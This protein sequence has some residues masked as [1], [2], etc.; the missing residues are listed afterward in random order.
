MVESTI[1][2]ETTTASFKGKKAQIEAFTEEE[3]EDGLIIA[4]GYTVNSLGRGNFTVDTVGGEDAIDHF[5]LNLD[6][7]NDGEVQSLRS[8]RDALNNSEVEEVAEEVE[9]AEETEPYT[10]PVDGLDEDTSPQQSKPKG[11]PKKSKEI[12]SEEYHE[13]EDYRGNTEALPAD[14]YTHRLECECGNI[15]W[16][17]P[18][19]VFQA[20]LCKPCTWEQRMERKREKARKKREARIAAEA[21][22]KARIKAEKDATKQAEK[23]AKAKARAEEKA[24][25]DAEREKAPSKKKK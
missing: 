15:R 17:K 12:S 20:T 3:F 7:F 22:E 8:T 13:Q 14:L 5:L 11:K 19:D 10:D 4:M 23:D 18:S 1:T 24:K 25:R 21:P 2:A 6:R 16:L 9:V